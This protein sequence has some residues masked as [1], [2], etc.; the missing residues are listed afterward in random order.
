MVNTTQEEKTNRIVQTMAKRFESYGYRKA[1]TQAFETYAMYGEVDHPMDPRDMIKLTNYDGELLVL[2]P[3]VTLPIAYR[4][5]EQLKRQ[6]ETEPMERKFYYVQEVFRQTFQPNDPI[7]T[8]Q[9][10][11][12]CFEP[13]RPEADAE[14]IALASH[15]LHDLNLSHH[16]FEV[17]FATFVDDLLAPYDLSTNELDEIERLIRAKNMAEL[18]QFLQPLTIDAQAK[19]IASNIPTFYG[20]IEVVEERLETYATNDAV[21]ETLDYLKRVDESLTLFGVDQQVVYDFG[22]INRMDYY[23]H[24]IFQAYVEGVGKPVLM[25]GRYDDLSQQFGVATPA[26]GFA[27]DMDLLVSAVPTAKEDE[28]ALDVAITYDE[29]AREAAIELAMNLRERFYRTVLGDRSDGALYDVSMTDGQIHVRTAT[30]EETYDNV[31][32]LLRSFIERQGAN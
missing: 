22:L 31:D 23:S 6:K 10:G 13:S 20:T 1:Q 3:D 21:K 18:Q 30:R 27:F 7:E 25:G 24:L 17:G 14:I 4:Y 11:I 28:Y 16:T 29:A 19:E 32:A 5:A 15:T 2:R 9:M 12:E 26:I 8:L